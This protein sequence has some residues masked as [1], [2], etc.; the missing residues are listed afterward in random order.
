VITVAFV[1]VLFWLIQR[2]PE[3]HPQITA[4]ASGSTVEIEP[5]V[6]CTVWLEDCTPGRQ[7]VLLVPRGEVLQ[8]SLPREIA[9]APWKLVLEYAKPDGTLYQKVIERTG[10]EHGAPAIT[11]AT[12]DQLTL[13]ELQLPSAVIDESG[14][15]AAH[16]F[17]S[18]RTA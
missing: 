10:A 9:D 17:W 14:A 16:A 7:S 3:K 2:A 1:A 8:L 4:F 5:M 18:L 12:K 11:I 15:R 6:Y 13:V